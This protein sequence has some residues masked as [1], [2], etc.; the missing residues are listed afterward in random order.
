MHEVTRL[1]CM[2]IKTL[3]THTHFFVPLPQLEGV[4]QDTGSSSGSVSK[5]TRLSKRGG[6]ASPMLNNP[7]ASTDG[8]LAVGTHTHCPLFTAAIHL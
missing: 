3:Q 5:A 4:G 2:C 1:A 7:E 8:A 6:M